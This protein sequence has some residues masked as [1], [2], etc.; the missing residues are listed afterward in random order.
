M[1]GEFLSPFL[2]SGDMVASFRSTGILAV[3]IV[4][5]IMWVTI[6]MVVSDAIFMNLMGIPSFPVAIESKIWNNSLPISSV[7]V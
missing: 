3:S 1:A 2:Y 6:G 7:L 5:F 4:R